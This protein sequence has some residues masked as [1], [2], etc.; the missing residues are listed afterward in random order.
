[1]MRL[2]AK[3]LTESWHLWLKKQSKAFLHATSRKPKISVVLIGSDPASLI[4]TQS[5][6]KKAAE[7]G[8]DG[9]L[10]RFPANAD[11][12]EVFLCIENLNQDPLVDGILIQRPLP[13]QFSEADVLLWVDPQKDVDAFHPENVGKLSLG[14]DC[15][16]PCTPS[17][18]MVLLD[19]YG[20]SLTG[21]TVGVV[22]RSSIVGKPMA[23]LALSQ[24]ATVIL[25][26]SR[27]R[28]LPARL[29]ECDVIVSAVGKPGLIRSSWLRAGSVVVDVGIN[30]LSDGRI[31]GD[32]TYDSPESHL[33][34]ATPVPGGVGPMT[35]TLLLTNTLIS[36]QFR[37]K[38]R[39][40]LDT[41][42]RSV[43]DP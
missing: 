42:I 38:L 26:H 10:I 20:V 43:I 1:M 31:V 6:T 18:C 28:D 7:L 21:K 2:E 27:T 35:I 33:S 15:L 22:G 3:P 40:T 24:D 37:E 5:K 30:R 36:A 34:G 4:Y 16:K 25:M 8:F 12:H 11:P 17:G 14:L 23:Q 19:H 41:P 39:S 32:V 13:P 9:D 29:N